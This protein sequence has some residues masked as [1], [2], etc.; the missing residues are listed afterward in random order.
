MFWLW[1]VIIAYFL[2]ALATL[3]SRWLLLKDLPH[4]VVFTFYIGALNLLALVLIPFGFYYPGFSEVVL[5]IGSGAAFGLGLYLMNKALHIDQVSQVAPMV[6]GLQPIFI[7]IFAWWFLPEQLFLKEYIGIGLLVLG[8]ILI[9]LEFGKRKIFTESIKLIL[10]SSIFFGLSYA[11][12]KLVYLQQEFISGFVWTRIGT[13]LFVAFLVLIT[14]K[15]HLVKQDLAGSGEKVKGWFILGQ[16]FGAVSFV[17]VAYA[18]SI[19]PVSVINA[20]QGLQYAI[21]FMLIVILAR[22]APQ[23]LDEPLTK[24]IIIQKVVSIL[25]IFIGLALVI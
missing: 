18:I 5:A 16:I 13:F 1:L 14:R 22:R 24:K 3:I 21:I 8:S 10:G 2:N 11:T 19:G 23:L 25:I 6:G 9:A 4:P 20:L 12:L 7:L 17:L 15:W